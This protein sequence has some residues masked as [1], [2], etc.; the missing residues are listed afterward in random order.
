MAGSLPRAQIPFTLRTTTIA[1]HQKSKYHYRNI[2]TVSWSQAMP[3]TERTHYRHLAA[4][5]RLDWDDTVMDILPIPSGRPDC[6]DDCRQQSALVPNTKCAICRISLFPDEVK[7][8]PFA[9]FTPFRQLLGR[10]TAAATGS[11]L[12]PKWQTKT[13]FPLGYDI[14]T[15]TA[16]PPDGPVFAVCAYCHSHPLRKH[17][18]SP[19]FPTDLTQPAGS[20]Q[21]PTTAELPYMSP[22]RCH[23]RYPC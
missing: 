2:L 8:L 5:L 17:F 4:A 18:H 7:H 16:T 22:V 12:A 19:L 9:S 14:F 3:P 1:H 11:D 6:I 20:F 15:R 21:P 23:D 13:L 10:R